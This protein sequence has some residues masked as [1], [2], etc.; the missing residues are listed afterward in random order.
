MPLVMAD[1]AARIALRA[2]T[3]LDK[4]PMMSSDVTRERNKLLKNLD[5]QLDL[6]VKLDGKGT[7]VAGRGEE[8]EPWHVPRGGKNKA[9][10]ARAELVDRSLVYTV[11]DFRSEFKEHPKAEFGRAFGSE[12]KGVRKASL[13]WDPP[14]F[15]KPK[16]RMTYSPTERVVPRKQIPMWTLACQAGAVYNV[17]APN[18]RRPQSAPSSPTLRS[19][20]STP[21]L[22]PSPSGSNRPQSAAIGSPVAR[23]QTRMRHSPAPSQQFGPPP[24]S[25]ASPLVRSPFARPV[26]GAAD[27]RRRAK[28][29]PRPGTAGSRSPE[30]RRLRTRSP[31]KREWQD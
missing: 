17:P 6:R 1:E 15:L 20:A 18:M 22:V 12:T 28:S 24:A 25:P 14:W 31:P 13:S 16:P 30:R 10:A 2:I 5:R 29:P 3:S 21:T 8:E 26:G 23:A 11:R 27:T 7:L 9:V 19:A 4:Q